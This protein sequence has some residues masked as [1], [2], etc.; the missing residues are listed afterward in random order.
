[1]ELKEH[2]KAERV[3]IVKP[4]AGHFAS[5]VD[6]N[7]SAEVRRFLGGPLQKAEAIDRA[8]YITGDHQ[9]LCWS[10]VNKSGNFL[11]LIIVHEHHDSEKLEISYQ[12]LPESWGQGYAFE[13]V[14][15]A[16][17]HL[18]K[19]LGIDQV[20]AETQQKNLQSIR[21]LKKLGFCELKLLERFGETQI[22][23]S[24]QA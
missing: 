17:E 18:F 22:L 3:S 6:L 20:L 5:L 9:E 7:T 19:K 8:T 1:M 4:S 16:L 15:V 2:M 10:V 23:F 11:G 14:Q 12:F 13:S 21:L 24:K